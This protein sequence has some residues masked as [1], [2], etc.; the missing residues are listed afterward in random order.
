MKRVIGIM[1]LCGLVSFTTGCGTLVNGMRQDLTVT[2]DPGGAEVSIDGVPR[3]TT[4]VVAAV[5]RRHAHVVKVEQPGYHPIETSVVQET[6]AWEWG[7][8][9]SWG[10]IGVVVDAL[11]G[12]MYYLS[13]DRVNVSFPVHQNR[14]SKVE[15][16]AAAPTVQ[17]PTP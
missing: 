10:P 1:A 2:S 11:T 13:Q 12:G 6:S 16:V 15:K 7:N 5:S 4:P 9:I 17:E 3:G 8:V 14:T